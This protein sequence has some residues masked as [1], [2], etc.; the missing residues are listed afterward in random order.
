V[1]KVRRWLVA[2]TAAVG[3]I[4]VVPVAAPAAPPSIVAKSCSGR[5]THALIQGAEKCIARG[6]FCARAADRQYRRYGL[7]CTKRDVY[8]RY[9]LV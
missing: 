2:A 3:L 9:H 8:G 6:Q 7:R 5:F 1:N 4:G